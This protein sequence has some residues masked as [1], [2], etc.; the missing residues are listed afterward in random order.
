MV[1]R[2]DDLADRL[3]REA[4][5][6]ARKAGLVADRTVRKD[7]LERLTS[8]LA[9]CESAL[10]EA[11]R[12]W[13]AAWAPAGI[14]P[15]SPGRM[16]TWL[17]ER[18]GLME[19]FREL[20]ER[21]QRADALEQA[22][23]TRR[24]EL[25]EQLRS[26]GLP[27]AE[28]GEPLSHLAARCRRV[29]ERQAA[30]AS[31]R[32]R[33]L[34]EKQDR[35]RERGEAEARLARA[36]QDLVRWREGW[37]EAVA[38]LGLGAEASPAQAVAVMEDVAALLDKVG[39]AGD[40][41]KRIAG[42]DRDA[43]DYAGRVGDLLAR[44]ASDLEARPPDQAV[45][46][47]QAR[48]NRAREESAQRARLEKER[49]R[50]EER[51]RRAEARVLELRSGLDVLCEEAC[52]RT[53]E[54]LA[55]AEKRSDRLRRVTADLEALEE[56][57]R[58][59]SG[60]RP[61][62]LFEQEARA[63]DPDEIEGKLLRLEEEIAGLRGEHAELGEAIGKERAALDRMDGS[64]RAAELAEE[65]QQIL[66]GLENSVE[67]YARLRIASAVL[68]RAVERYREK[69][70]GPVLER[71]NALFNRLTL[72]RFDGVRAEYDEQGTPVL[73]GIRPGG[74]IVP[75]AGMSEGTADQLYLAL[76]LASLEDYLENGE[77]MPFVVDDILIKFDDDRARAALE[78]LAEL[79][80]KTQVVFFTHHRHLL[81][82]ARDT[83][84]VHV[85]DLLA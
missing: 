37:A 33:L 36:E 48:L 41:Q 62:D 27:P 39:E 10:E 4:D 76:R 12:A 65:A 8:R 80:R 64:P 13:R 66:A 79:S 47:L 29:V 42:I 11:G 77:P 22:F 53:Y 67:R 46:E 5:R 56:Q 2:A 55:E 3:R 35:E 6:V 25:D 40:L 28:D 83:E 49:E 14:D 43:G 69:H 78:L 82:L 72:G 16:R 32:E 24:R 26:L 81:E 9:K 34:S 1:R 71:T 44:A 54:A 20:R 31:E 68:A 7:R 75:V 63:V 60:G 38:P 57:L 84:G 61:V 21:E 58:G 18:Q 73:V 51:V 50:R 70:Q 17:K 45:P 52:C 85:G 23:A 19:R 30:L 74:E 59:L 15:D